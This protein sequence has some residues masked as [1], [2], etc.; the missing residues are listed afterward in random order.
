[1][2]RWRPCIKRSMRVLLYVLVSSRDGREGP[3]V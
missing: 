3:V 1:M 2:T